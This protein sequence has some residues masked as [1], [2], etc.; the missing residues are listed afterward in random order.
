MSK[1]ERKQKIDSAHSLPVTQQCRLLSVSR[2][3]AYY[4]P[5]PPSADELQLM[6]SLFHLTKKIDKVIVIPNAHR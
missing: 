1:P 5:Q 6:A 4:K 2:S 3:S